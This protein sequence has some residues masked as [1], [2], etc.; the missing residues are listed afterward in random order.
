MLAANA[1]A[2]PGGRRR[3]PPTARDGKGGRRV[4]ETQ[5]RRLGTAVAIGTAAR[6]SSRQ[7]VRYA[8]AV[9]SARPVVADRLRDRSGRRTQLVSREM[10]RVREMSR[11]RGGAVRNRMAGSKS[12]ITRQAQE[13][14]EWQADKMRTMSVQKA[15][16]NQRERAQYVARVRRQAGR[17]RRNQEQ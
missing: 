7:A 15:G 8:V 4:R 13:R 12:R 9:S 1:Q 10:D 17:S 6:R 3:K 2:K 16:D 14:S 11:R 5:W